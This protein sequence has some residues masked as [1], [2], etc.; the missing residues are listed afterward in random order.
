M[1][2]LLSYRINDTGLRFA[3]ENGDDFTYETLN[4][5]RPYDTAVAKDSSGN[6]YMVYEMDV[7]DYFGP[8]RDRLKITTKRDGVW[9]E[10]DIDYGG[11]FSSTAMYGMDFKI[12]EDDIAHLVY[13]GEGALWYATFPVEWVT[14]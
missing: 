9:V 14:E 13:Q 10:K 5:D 12:D 11:T 2:K 6:V 8:D 4:Y 3:E 7:F 1:K